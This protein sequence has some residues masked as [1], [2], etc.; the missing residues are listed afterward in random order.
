MWKLNL[1]LSLEGVYLP[2]CFEEQDDFWE[3]SQDDER[4]LVMRTHVTFL[5]PFKSQVGQQCDSF[6]LLTFLKSP[7]FIYLF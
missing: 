2:L 6:K 1:F 3:G 4:L 7:E 5:Q